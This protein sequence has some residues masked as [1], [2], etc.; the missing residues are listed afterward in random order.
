MQ[1]ARAASYSDGKDL[2]SIRFYD[3]TAYGNC[4]MCQNNFV[5]SMTRVANTDMEL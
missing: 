1:T 5:F 3:R 4:L 2:S